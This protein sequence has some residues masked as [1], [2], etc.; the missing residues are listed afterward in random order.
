MR[1]ASPQLLSPHPGQGWL[2]TAGVNTHICQMVRWLLGAVGLAVEGLRAAWDSGLDAALVQARLPDMP[3]R[4]HP[5]SPG[6]EPLN[7]LAMPHWRPEG[8][9]ISARAQVQVA[10]T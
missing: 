8:K 2:F 5:S 1:A 3:V 6:K 9:W 7:W 4:V 10:E